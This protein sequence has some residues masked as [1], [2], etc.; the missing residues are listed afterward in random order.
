MSK[1]PILTMVVALSHRYMLQLLAEELSAYHDN[2]LLRMGDQS[3]LLDELKRAMGDNKPCCLADYSVLQTA[4]MLKRGD[5][6]AIWS[7]YYPGLE[8][9]L[10]KWSAFLEN[11]MTVHLCSDLSHARWHSVCQWI[12]RGFTWLRMFVHGS[13][14]Q[15]ADWL[16]RLNYFEQCC[17]V[18]K[19]DARR[20][21]LS[22][23]RDHIWTPLPDLT[24]PTTACTEYIPMNLS[25]R[26]LARILSELQ[27]MLDQTSNQ[28]LDDDDQL[29]DNNDDNGRLSS[30]LPNPADTVVN[31]TADL[32]LWPLAMVILER[33]TDRRHMILTT[34]VFQ[35]GWCDTAALRARVLLLAMT[36]TSSLSALSMV[37]PGTAQPEACSARCQHS[38]VKQLTTE[39]L[40]L[41]PMVV[42]IS[43]Q[44]D[45]LTTQRILPRCGF[46]HSVV[47]FVALFFNAGCF[48]SVI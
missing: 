40:Q 20:L 48:N 7:E 23:V 37:Q 17:L 5:I 19:K 6:P 28:L 36:Q 39:G 27:T 44:Y 30:V 15:P 42:N 35:E 43:S 1:A 46:G 18:S 38:V 31:A 45:L 21:N 3:S 24:P 34:D 22:A 32:R 41:D 2:H 12:T 47:C 29:D 14:G 26:I 8:S 4:V 16:E 10:A 33:F 25:W 9:V 11:L 13:L